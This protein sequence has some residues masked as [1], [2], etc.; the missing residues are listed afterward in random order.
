MIASATIQS[1]GASCGAR[2][3]A[4]PKLMM[5]LGA[6]CDRAL[7]LRDHPQRVAAMDDGHALPGGDVRLEGKAGHRD[8]GQ[9]VGQGG[10]MPNITDGALPALILR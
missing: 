8:D 3:P 1:P 2:P 6:H 7:Q 5:P 9:A 10:H 4:V